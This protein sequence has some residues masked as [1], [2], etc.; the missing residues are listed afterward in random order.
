MPQAPVQE[1]PRP[2]GKTPQQIDDFALILFQKPEIRTYKELYDFLDTHPNL[3]E[4]A[5]SNP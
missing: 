3:Y 4:K 2:P 5:L 1:P